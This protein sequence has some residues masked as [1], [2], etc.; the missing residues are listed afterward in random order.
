M[1]EEYVNVRGVPLKLIDTAGIRQTDD[2]VEQ[3]G[4]QR[5]KKAI[6]QA[7][8]VM[9]VLNASEKLTPQDRQLLE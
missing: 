7:D 2:K 3:I 6:E 1:I 9:L 5:S 8:L 4:V